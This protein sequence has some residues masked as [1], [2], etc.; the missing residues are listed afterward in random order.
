[1]KK[2]LFPLL[3]LT[4][5]SALFSSAQAFTFTV[6]NSFST[7]TPIKAA[8]MNANFQSLQEELRRL[9]NISG[10]GASLTGGGAEGW[11]VTNTSS[12]NVIYGLVG[13]V[14]QGGKY[15]AG[16][17]GMDTTPGSLSY[18]VEGRSTNGAGVYGSSGTGGGVVGVSSSGPA[19]KAISGTAGGT[20]LELDGAIKVSGTV[21]PAF[22]HTAAG[23]SHI[24]CI[25]NALTNGDPNA[26]VTFVHR[27]D[28]VYY[29]KPFA[30]YYT[31]GKWC[32][33][34]EDT[35]QLIS[36]GTKFNVLVI[37]Q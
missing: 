12:D 7:G 31:S 36:A 2:I 1:M 30:I 5:S 19:V 14:T 4:L 6:P 22:V 18:G 23:G 3:A 24:T 37:K 25:D 10:F 27:W 16:I 20:A 26:I 21:R 11:T 15:S 29:T 9:G 33:F 17:K 34:S 35:A 8:D 28:A 32:I 13:N